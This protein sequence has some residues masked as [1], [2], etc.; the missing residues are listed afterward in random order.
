MKGGRYLEEKH[1]RK[2][3]DTIAPSFNEIPQKVWPNVKKFIK[4]LYPGSLVADIGCGNGRYLHINKSVYKFG[5]DACYPLVELSGEKGYEVLVADNQSLPFRDGAFDGVISV[6]VLHHFSTEQ[7]RVQALKELCR[8]LRPGGKLLVYVWAYEQKHRRFDGQDVLIPWHAGKK[9]TQKGLFNSDQD[10]SSTSSISEDESLDSTRHVI[11]R[12]VSDPSCPCCQQ[13][14]PTLINKLLS[15]KPLSSRQ[16]SNTLPSSL[17]ALTGNHDDESEIQEEC[18]KLQISLREMSSSHNHLSASNDSVFCNGATIE[19]DEDGIVFESKHFA[20]NY[21]LSR[22]NEISACE[23]ADVSNLM[24]NE[25]CQIPYQNLPS[26]HNLCDVNSN[27][28]PP[29][30]QPEQTGIV[31]DNNEENLTKKMSFF[32][33]MKKR[34]LK[35]ID[36]KF[37]NKSP[38]NHEPSVEKRK[39]SS[40]NKSGKSRNIQDVNSPS[41]FTCFAVR[42]FPLSSCHNYR[43]SVSSSQDQNSIQSIYDPSHNTTQSAE[44][45]YDNGH[46]QNNSTGLQVEQLSPWLHENFDNAASKSDMLSTG[47]LDNDL[48]QSVNTSVYD[49]SIKDPQNS[50][51]LSATSISNSQQNSHFDLDKSHRN[52]DKNGRKMCNKTFING[53]QET[54]N[55]DVIKVMNGASKKQCNKVLNCH[56]QQ[57]GGMC[58]ITHLDSDQNSPSDILKANTSGKLS[59]DRDIPCDHN[60]SHQQNGNTVSGNHNGFNNNLMNGCDKSRHKKYNE[61]TETNSISGETTNQHNISRETTNCQNTVSHFY[62]SKESCSNEYASQSECK[63][64]MNSGKNNSLLKN[65]SDEIFLKN[66]TTHN[67]KR[68]QNH[69]R[70]SENISSSR[71]SNQQSFKSCDTLHNGANYVP[72]SSSTMTEEEFRMS[73]A[74][75][76]RFYHVFKQ[77]ELSDLIFKYVDNLCI[78]SCTY[79]HG[80]WCLIAEKR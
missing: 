15:S 45:L 69:I 71:L 1:V 42:E 66:G 26:T 37:E 73:T 49:Q 35:F 67:D 60:L 47:P 22:E 2:V 10:I 39:T 7:R 3:Y 57:Q 58:N 28:D 59:H 18:R 19:N 65:K 17:E 9:I 43:D 6:G 50:L 32:E 14:Q 63:N 54:K 16:R 30:G 46:I 44:H 62:Y 56:K 74:R 36:S 80:N 33:T 72:F 79:D 53:H 20:N 31:N 48:G 52:V 61:T 38:T 51:G 24:S 41:S 5:V 55:Q 29:D 8:I 64:G 11:Q 13:S 70:S 76:C 78:V 40:E 21:D 23:K 27:V 77:G 75:L 68:N 12:T 25:P 4:N 34:F